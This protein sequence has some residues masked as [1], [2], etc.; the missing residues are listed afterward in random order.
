[1]TA[2]LAWV[3]EALT[4]QDRGPPRRVTRQEYEDWRTVAAW[5]LLQGLRLGQS[6]CQRFD[7]RDLWLYNTENSQQADRHIRRHY[8]KRNVRPTQ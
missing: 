7:I 1:M 6:F 3:V 8:L 5:D 4:N 2:G